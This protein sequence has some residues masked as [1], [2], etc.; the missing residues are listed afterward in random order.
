MPSRRAVAGGGNCCRSRQLHRMI[1]ATNAT[2][3]PNARHQ[4]SPDSMRDQY[5]WLERA[6]IRLLKSVGQ[7]NL[8]RSLRLRPFSQTHEEAMYGV[9]GHQLHHLCAY[10]SVVGLLCCDDVDSSRRRPVY[11]DF[12]C[13]VSRE[14]F[15]SRVLRI[16]LSK[17][18]CG[19]QPSWPMIFRASI[20]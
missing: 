14:R 10:E 1:L 8:C 6:M 7:P 17:L 3:L 9:K 5:F 20:A 18:S 4:A 19:N 15:H 11:H 13:S 12:I 2:F 16:P